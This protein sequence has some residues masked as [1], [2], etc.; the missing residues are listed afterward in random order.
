[1]EIRIQYQGIEGSPWM[2]KYLEGKLARLERYLSSGARTEIDLISNGDQCVSVLTVK[3]LNHE[4]NF[5]RE[6]CDVFEAFSGSL[7][8]ALMILK[9][10][11]MKI[12]EKY[13]KA[14]IDFIEP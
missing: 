13:Q 10:E 5:D 7:D 6:G 1:M 9:R 12:H 3:T 8:E 4:Y 2:T 11:H 14:I